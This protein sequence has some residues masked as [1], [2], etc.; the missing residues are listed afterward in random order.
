MTL[1]IDRTLAL[2]STYY[3]LQLECIERM[4]A[5]TAY[6]ANVLRNTHGRDS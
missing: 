2:G 5:D 6:T 1:R 3:E 4:T